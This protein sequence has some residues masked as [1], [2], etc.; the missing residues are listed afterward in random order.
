MHHERA[1]R[2]EELPLFLPRSDEVESASGPLNIRVDNDIFSHDSQTS[3][4]WQ[5]RPSQKAISE[6]KTTSEGGGHVSGALVRAGHHTQQR[7][8]SHTHA[9]TPT[10]VAVPP[11]S[12]YDPYNWF[13][14]YQH[15]YREGLPP[16]AWIALSHRKRATLNTKNAVRAACCVRVLPQ[17]DV[18]KAALKKPAADRRREWY[19][20]WESVSACGAESR[21]GVGT[22]QRGSPSDE[23]AM[24]Y[25]P[26]PH[27][28]AAISKPEGHEIHVHDAFTGALLLR[29]SEPKGQLAVTTLLHAPFRGFMDR[30]LRVI[31]I[32]KPKDLLRLKSQ[33]LVDTDYVWV[34][35]AD[36]SVRLF[37]ANPNRIRDTDRSE[38]MSRGELEDVVFELPKYHNA[39]IIAISRSPCHGDDKGMDLST[40]NRLSA[41]IDYMAAASTKGSED[42]REHL[43]LMCT[44]SVDSSIVVWD[45][46]KIYQTMEAMRVQKGGGA[47]RGRNSR[48]ARWGDYNDE[49]PGAVDS[50]FYS[51]SASGDVVTIDGYAAGPAS[52]KKIF[53]VRSACTMIKVRPVLKLKGGI[54]ALKSIQWVSTLVTTEGYQ[55]RRRVTDATRD[56]EEQS[57]P[58]FVKECRDIQTLTRFQRRE[59]HRRVLRL[60]ESEMREVEDELKS[61]MP[62]LAEEPVQSLRINLIIAGDSVGSI[63]LWNLDEE[64]RYKQMQDPFDCGVGLEKHDISP[65][66]IGSPVGT[67]TDGGSVSIR[68][69]SE[70][71]GRTSLGSHQMRYSTASPSVQMSAL[72]G[73]SKLPRRAKAPGKVPKSAP[74]RA[75]STATV[76]LLSGPSKGLALSAATK[77]TAPATQ[78]KETKSSL[79]SRPKVGFA[80]DRATPVR[81]TKRVSPSTIPSQPKPSRRMEEERQDND[82]IEPPSSA[83]AATELLR[84]RLSRLQKLATVQRDVHAPLKAINAIMDSNELGQTPS[85]NPANEIAANPQA[86]RRSNVVSKTSTPA[87]PTDTTRQRVSQSQIKVA[88]ENKSTVSVSLPH[89]KKGESQVSERAAPTKVSTKAKPQGRVQSPQG[90]N[91]TSPRVVTRNDILSR[92]SK[93]RIEFTGGVAITGMAIDVPDT[94]RTTLRQCPNPEDRPFSLLEELLPEEVERRRLENSFEEL[95]EHKALFFVFKHLQLYVSVEGVVLNLECTPSWHE[96]SDG[97]EYFR[98][99]KD[100]DQ[101]DAMSSLLASTRMEEMPVVGEVEFPCFTVQLRKRTLE[102]HSQPVIQLLF[103]KAHGLVW[104]ARNDGLLSLFSKDTKRIVTRVAHP[105]ADA[106]LGPPPY[107][108]WKKQQQAYLR[109][110]NLVHSQLHLEWHEETKGYEPAHFNSFLPFCKRSQTTLILLSGRQQTRTEDFKVG[111]PHSLW[112]EAEKYANSFGLAKS[113]EPRDH[114][115]HPSS[116]LVF[117]QALKLDGRSDMDVHACHRERCLSDLFDRFVYYRGMADQVRRAQKD[118]YQLQCN[119]ISDRVRYIMQEFTACTSFSTL[120]QFYGIW[121]KHARDYRREHILRRQRASRILQLIPLADIARRNTTIAHQGRCFYIWLRWCAK[122]VMKHREHVQQRF[123]LHL[124]TPTRRLPT[125]NMMQ[126]LWEQHTQAQIYKFWKS[127]VGTSGAR[128]RGGWHSIAT[129]SVRSTSPMA[130]PIACIKSARQGYNNLMNISPLVRTETCT[131]LAGVEP[132]VAEYISSGPEQHT[133]VGKYYHN[134]DSV[135]NKQDKLTSATDYTHSTAY[136]DAFQL[137]KENISPSEILPESHCEDPRLVSGF[138]EIMA[139]FFDARHA[140]MQFKENNTSS[141]SVLDESWLSIVKSS[142]SGAEVDDEGGRRLAVFSYGLLPLLQGLLSTATDVLSNLNDPSVANEVISLM[143]GIQFCMDYVTADSVDYLASLLGQENSAHSDVSTVLFTTDNLNAMS[144]VDYDNKH[145]EFDSNGMLH[146]LKNARLQNVEKPPRKI[147]TSELGRHAFQMNGKS[148]KSTNPHLMSPSSVF[149][150]IMRFFVIKAMR[151]QESLDALK[152]VIREKESLESFISFLEDENAVERRCPLFT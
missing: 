20:M 88:K 95:T 140:M 105:C 72:G 49:R 83:G 148:E 26:T 85:N 52:H 70:S 101:G 60:N 149:L 108:E 144:S 111:H 37:P 76:P 127:L 93:C 98:R 120:S 124:M 129:T 133:P 42:N 107:A 139:L 150:S 122:R 10:P 75:T 33:Q 97:Y 58:K 86:K 143:G 41:A 137:E 45:V 57:A 21:S 44:A 104:V 43:S 84:G 118:N 81:T 141:Q 114:G 135:F 36:G 115:R 92:A 87:R 17:L 40:M 51:D 13:K 4:V 28:W 112:Y 54:T 65:Q 39:S 62:A 100:L 9:N 145:K 78:G 121:K 68:N 152:E 35:F 113:H 74:K 46:R 71:P 59:E 48:G 64:L 67:M 55:V 66:R 16:S 24:A 102:A 126:R 11:S 110:F 80:T 31:S 12:F 116:C 14:T 132:Q 27:I 23:A 7:H 131:Y 96:D 89:R 18:I 90:R 147:N 22:R 34:G 130:T 47:V 142:E 61:L 73:V 91:S 138:L 79:L 136:I 106:A 69:A 125:G 38:R 30:Q 119:L 77:K 50:V 5:A 146:A 53:C 29:I 117:L 32:H 19:E 109:E 151:D 123:F 94:L 82:N 8:N 128:H 25:I 2:R 1:R 99:L 56:A 63:H 6:T 134:G 103:D 15:L 3:L